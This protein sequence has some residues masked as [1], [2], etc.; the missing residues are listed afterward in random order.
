VIPVGHVLREL[1]AERTRVLLTILAIAWGSA[2]ISVMLALGEGLRLTFGRSMK[3]MGE[4]IAIAWQ[5][6]TS[7]AH[8][9]LP[10][11]YSLPLRRD[12]RDRF[13]ASIPEIAAISGEYSNWAPMRHGTKWRNGHLMGVD[14]EYGPMRNIT[15]DPGGRF[16]D[17]I[18]IAQQRRVAVL[19]PQVVSELYGKGVDPVGQ[20]I[21]IDGWP[22][23][24]IGVMHRKYQ[25]ASYEGQDRDGTWIP[26]T[27]FETRYGWRNYSNLVI[28]PDRPENMLRVRARIR[29]V[30]ASQRGCDPEDKEIVRFWDTVEVQGM[31]DN[32][33]YGLQAVLGIIGGLT[34]IVAGVGIA[35]VMYVSVSNA[36]ADIG[37]RMAVGA[38]GY[39][40]LG[41]YVLEALAA[42]ALGGALGVGA[43]ALV[44]GIVGQIPMKGD[45]LEVVGKPVP[46]LS[47]NVALIVVVVLGV[48]GFL[49][50]FFPAR[51]AAQVDP[52]EALRYE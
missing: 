51:K 4:G 13:R 30:L 16:I 9:G 5:G 14:P 23:L 45:F 46:V 3:G 15:P 27:T 10:E 38:R 39:Q 20:Q 22:F 26:S 8:G 1:F 43:S 28:K 36:T 41:Q 32:V 11:G 24:V 40:V 25:T 19:S 34:L 44:I 50:G 47:L 31:T 18:D 33:L 21:E 17:P 29:Q 52:A 37:V 35:N 2:S 12:D 49:A 7:K 6:Q 42:T 48:V